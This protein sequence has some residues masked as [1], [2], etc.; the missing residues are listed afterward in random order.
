M[1]KSIAAAVHKV[2]PTL[3]LA[4]VKTLDQI[5]D[6]DLSGERFSV[7]LYASFAAIALVAGGDRH[8][9]RD[10]VLGGRAHP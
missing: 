6:E 4:E 9:R 10:G 8:L 5:R 1:T 3:A 2:D 7:F